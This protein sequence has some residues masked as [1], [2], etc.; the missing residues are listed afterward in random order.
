MGIKGVLP[1]CG[2]TMEAQYSPDHIDRGWEIEEEI[3][4]IATDGD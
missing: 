2:I 1:T 4:G 3:E